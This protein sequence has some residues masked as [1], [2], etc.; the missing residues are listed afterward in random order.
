[1]KLSTTLHD[2]TR[3][4]VSLPEAIELLARTPFR[5]ADFC[6]S[7]DTTNDRWAQTATRCAEVA[8]ANGITFVQAHGIDIDPLKK[9]AETELLIAE[10][11]LAICAKLGI[12]HVVFHALF[13]SDEPYP[14]GKEHFFECNRKFFSMLL[15]PPT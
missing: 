15:R 5:H 13:C 8:Q 7:P 1:M 2:F 12:P 14:M 10:R 4:G 6:F 9:D 3:Y 11:T